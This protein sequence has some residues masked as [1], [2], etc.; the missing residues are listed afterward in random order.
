LAEFREDAKQFLPNRVRHGN[1]SSTIGS[2]FAS[3]GKSPTISTVTVDPG[4]N[5]ATRV[6]RV[7]PS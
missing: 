6:A 7:T 1:R 2:W 5:R 3:T 4:V